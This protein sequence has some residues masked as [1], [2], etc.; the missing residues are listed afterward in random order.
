MI[1]NCQGRSQLSFGENEN[2][3][4]EQEFH[5]EQSKSFD[6]KEN[7]LEKTR[8]IIEKNQIQNQQLAQQVF[9]FFRIT[10]LFFIRISRR[11]FSKKNSNEIKSIQQLVDILIV[12]LF[13]QLQQRT[14]Q[15]NQSL[16][17]FLSFFIKKVHFWFQIKFFICK[18]TSN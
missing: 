5:V 15:I 14:K 1:L 12:L 7:V 4:V 6:E 11:N 3:I 16:H 17:S 13:I 18:S 9:L 8:Q 10:K 2:S